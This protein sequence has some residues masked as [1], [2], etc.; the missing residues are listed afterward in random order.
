VAKIRVGQFS[1][2]PVLAAIKHLNFLPDY[3]IEITNAVSSPAQFGALMKNEM[4]I[5]LTSP[6]NVLLYGTTDKNPLE[7]ICDLK[8]LSSIDK[9]LKLS[10]VS[11]A[12]IQTTKDLQ[13]AIFCIDS[14][15]SGFAILLKKMLLQLGVD[16]SALNIVA[17][18][19]TPMRVLHILKNESQASI[20]NAESKLKAD[21][22]S[23]KTWMDVSEVA[24]NYMGT[25]ICVKGQD[26]ETQ[27]TK[28]FMQAW[29]KA[30][31]WI[32]ESDLNRFKSI[33][34]DQTSVLATSEYFELL[35]D[36]QHGMTLNNELN[37]EALKT[38]IDIRKAAGAY[39]PDLS[40]IDN[41]I[42]RNYE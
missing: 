22:E 17:A 14:P 25:V 21:Q 31:K 26:E 37:F 20:L 9:G 35:K 27:S 19:S 24:D 3:E 38:L 16:I 18:G 33:F 34:E 10:L 36:K 28:D 4:D 41:L 30:V 1:Q 6:D 11:S 39:Q 12:A 5:A 42:S 2:S 7:Q 29:Q 15:T 40:K 23:L 32:L 8:M 13:N